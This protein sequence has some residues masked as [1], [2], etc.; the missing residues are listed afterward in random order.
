MQAIL[1]NDTQISVTLAQW[2]SLAS[3]VQYGMY[4]AWGGVGAFYSMQL[5]RTHT[6]LV[7][8]CAVYRRKYWLCGG[9]IFPKACKWHVLL[10]STFNF[11]YIFIHYF[12]LEA[13][14]YKTYFT[15]SYLFCVFQLFFRV[16]VQNA[17]PEYIYQYPE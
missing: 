1:T 7:S 8:W 14:D 12:F 16:S 3:I 4:E 13:Y 2:R 17:L 15:T 11:I 5:F 6:L 9:F 10:L